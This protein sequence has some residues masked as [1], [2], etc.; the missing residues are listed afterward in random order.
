I[1]DSAEAKLTDLGLVKDLAS[2]A[3][4]TQPGAW[5]GTVAY[6]APEQFGNARHVDLTCDVYGLAA[7]L[8]FT[9]TGAPPFAGGNL[10]V[11]NKKNKGDFRP[12]SRVVSSLPKVVDSV[13]A[14]GLR[15]NPKDR[16]VS[17][18][19]LIAMLSDVM[20]STRGSAAAPA[21]RAKSRRGAEQRK[22]V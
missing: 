20:P 1:T 11:L 17:C 15:P 12:P 18:G 9:L 14:S 13:I 22:A 19:K 8:Y 2:G 6:M 5:L 16:P 3:D 21:D 4:L 7:T 10:K